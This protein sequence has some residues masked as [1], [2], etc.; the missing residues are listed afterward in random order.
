MRILYTAP[1]VPY[2]PHDGGRLISFHY[3]KGLAQRGHELT[4][5]LP[6]RRPEDL[7]SAEQLAELGEVRTVP[8]RARST[9][10]IAWEALRYRESL[11]IRRHTLPE[12]VSP[13]VRA[14]ADPFDLVFLDSLFT[15][16]LLPFVRLERPR[17]PVVLLELNSESQVFQRL[18]QVRGTHFLRLL[19]LW[20]QPRITTAERAATR[21]VDRVLTL[22]DQDERTL[23]QLAGDIDTAV[24]GPGIPTYRGATIP[25][26]PDAKSVLFLGSYH[27]PPNRDGARWLAREIW[28][29]VRTRHP[30][31]R[32][33]LAGADPTGEIARLA[34]P[35]LGIEALGFVEDAV[36]V[37]REVAVTVVPLRIG[38]GVR[39]KILEALANE[40][41]VV[42]TPLGAEGLSLTPGE[43]A[44]YAESAPDFADAVADLLADPARA[45]DLAVAGRKRVEALYSWDAVIA[46]LEQL[47]EDVAR[48]DR[49]PARP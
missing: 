26:P 13:F 7:E 17:L 41:P 21:G 49:A 36:A 1:F 18:V 10:A 29:R 32:L 46:R 3:L 14:L 44:L 6:L 25:P 12:I 28:P 45:H 16:Y 31:A 8:V 40:R 33:L 15:A 20:E 11:R 47:L 37:T 34:D 4:L 30:E 43:H 2:P 35:S 5:V 19:A 48:Q 39:L 38:G 22:S 42:T 9:A 23:R 24:V 27:W